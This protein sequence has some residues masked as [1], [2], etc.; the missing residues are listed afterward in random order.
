MTRE[1]DRR[2][3]C[4]SPRQGQE[5]C[6]LLCIH[7]YMALTRGYKITA[8]CT[9]LTSYRAKTHPEA[10]LNAMHVKLPV[11]SPRRSWEEYSLLLA[12]QSLARPLIFSNTASVRPCR[13]RSMQAGPCTRLRGDASFGSAPRRLFYCSY[14]WTVGV[15]V[16]LG[17]HNIAGFDHS[18]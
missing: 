17:Q 12:S 10:L 3:P 9:R 4:Q 11:L 15:G 18:V 7:P 8:G 13:S 5:P 2:L 16:H 6:S 1:K 14:H